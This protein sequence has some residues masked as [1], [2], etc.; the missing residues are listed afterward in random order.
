MAQFETGKSKLM[1][2]SLLY[3]WE[4]LK[5]LNRTKFRALSNIIS[6]YFKMRFLENKSKR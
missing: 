5:T 3:F 2:G 1:K 4:E 6:G